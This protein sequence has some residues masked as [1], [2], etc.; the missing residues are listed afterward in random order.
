MDHR[1][2]KLGKLIIGNLGIET[3]GIIWLW[4]WRRPSEGHRLYSYTFGACVL[5]YAQHLE[6]LHHYNQTLA[7]EP[8]TPLR[9][10]FK[11]R[12]LNLLLR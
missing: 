5:S 4:P 11:Q 9:M 10:T 6:E 2:L 3:C 1:Y 8:W 12:L 7:E